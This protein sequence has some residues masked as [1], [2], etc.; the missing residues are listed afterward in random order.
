MQMIVSEK[1]RCMYAAV[2]GGHKEIFMLLM[3][4]NALPRT[5]VLSKA[6]EL[7]LARE[8]SEAEI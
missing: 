3:Q 2:S 8:A 4:Y 5:A 7:L 1:Q 6:V